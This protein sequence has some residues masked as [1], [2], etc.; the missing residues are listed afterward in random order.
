MARQTWAQKRAVMLVL[1]LL[2]FPLPWI[3]SIERMHFFIFNFSVFN[4]TSFNQVICNMAS[5]I[6]TVGFAITMLFSVILFVDSYRRIQTGMTNMLAVVF[7]VATM[8]PI[9]VLIN[10]SVNRYLWI[11]TEF[12]DW[13]SLLTGLLCQ[14]C[15]I[16]AMCIIVNYNL[17]KI[18]LSADSGIL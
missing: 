7:L 16:I 1:T 13:F 10:E 9:L 11:N 4:S 17:D 18:N 8:F 3:L 5:F 15:Y 2:L 6:Y 12:A 14:T